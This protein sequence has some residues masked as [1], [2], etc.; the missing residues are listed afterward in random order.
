[1]RHYVIH[2]LLL[3]IP[4]LVLVTFL[5]FSIVRVVPGSVVDLM[6]QENASG[7]S[8]AELRHK[9]GLDQP[10]P[11]QYLQWVGQIAHGDFGRSLWN[12]QATADQLKQAM[13]ITLELSGLGLLL[14]IST[15]LLI[16]T[17]A[18]MRADTPLDYLLRSFSIFGLSVPDFWLATLVVTFP[19][20]WWGVTPS[21]TFIPFLEDPAGNLIQF[22]IPAAILGL[23]RSAGFMRFTRTSMLDV[24]RK[25][26]MRTA[27]AKGL[28]EPVMISR[29]ALKNSLIPVVTLI[30]L[31]VPALL[32]G[33]VILESIFSLPGMGQLTLH[34]IS[35]RDYPVLQVIVLF[36]T[37]VVLISN[38]VVDV[39]YGWLD[40]R[41]RFS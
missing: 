11:Q 3:F 10:I 15:G 33:T 36:Y 21:F 39:A 6:L 29:H 38:L 7:F 31:A 40:P 8:P 27:R 26:Y 5:V 32:S 16:G 37:L 4:S 28:R 1:M 23:S 2:R 24:L 9:L 20:I 22:I 25:D 12:N 14:S 19:A 34:S 35:Q 41:I 13:P 17:I 30:G 18:A